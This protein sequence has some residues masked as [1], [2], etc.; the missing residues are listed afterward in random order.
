M[1]K[2]L[3]FESPK[4]QRLSSYQALKLMWPLH[5]RCNSVDKWHHN[6]R[7]HH[8]SD[9]QME[10]LT[11]DPSLYFRTSS[12]RLYGLSGTNVDDLLRCGNLCLFLFSQKPS[13]YSTLHQNVVEKPSLPAS[14]SNRKGRGYHFHVHG[15]VHRQTQFSNTENVESV[16][17]FRAKMAWIMYCRPDVCPL[18]AKAAQIT[19]KELLKNPDSQF[20][21]LFWTFNN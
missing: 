9:L 13:T 6:L 21:L 20:G 11:T 8:F 1:M 14:Q 7:H 3:F 12:D 2:E 10:P 18:V 4:E 17:F 15:R 19:E 5:G 16:D